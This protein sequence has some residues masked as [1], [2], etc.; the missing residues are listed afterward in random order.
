VRDPAAESFGGTPGLSRQGDSA[1]VEVHR[2]EP[3]R[4]GSFP[5]VR[6]KV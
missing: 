5:A 6:D 2:T 1:P 3:W 4:A